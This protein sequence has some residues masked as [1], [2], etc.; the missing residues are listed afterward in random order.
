LCAHG[1]A[2]LSSLSAP[3]HRA[4]PRRARPFPHPHLSSTN[5]KQ[6]LTQLTTGLSSEYSR[7]PESADR[8]ASRRVDAD[9]SLFAK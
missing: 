5:K 1:P 4:P 3:R 7:A 8:P 2:T 6:K 9:K